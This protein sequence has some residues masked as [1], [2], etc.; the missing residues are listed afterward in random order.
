MKR[1]KIGLFVLLSVILFGYAGTVDY[2]EAVVYNMP[3]VIYDGIVEEHPDFSLKYLP[4]SVGERF[5]LSRFPNF[6]KS[7]SVSG[8]KKLYYGKD[9]LL[10]RCGNYIYNVSSEPDIYHSI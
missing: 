2:T 5:N 8:M 6:H 9:A 10:V 4:S 1:K 3:Q 7:G